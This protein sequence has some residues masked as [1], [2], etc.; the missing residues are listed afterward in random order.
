MSWPGAVTKITSGQTACPEK[1]WRNCPLACGVRRYDE[2]DDL[3][4]TNKALARTGPTVVV[5]RPFVKAEPAPPLVQGEA[6]G[7]GRH[8]LSNEWKG[9]PRSKLAAMR[10]PAPVGVGRWAEV[11]RSRRASKYAVDH[12]AQIPPGG[13]QLIRYSSGKSPASS[14]WIG[15]RAANVVPVPR[16]G[17]TSS[18]PPCAWRSDCRRRGQD[19]ALGE[20]SKCCAA[21]RA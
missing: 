9:P 1:G 6:Q 17:I 15:S 20:L 3:K 14:P 13:A 4:Y 7:S 21:R 18:D 16:S 12:S 10:R 19:P 11:K 2:S 5:D 8:L